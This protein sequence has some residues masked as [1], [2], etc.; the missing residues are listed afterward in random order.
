MRRFDLHTGMAKLQTSLDTLR[1]QWQETADSWRDD[2]R[3][4]FAENYLD[5]IGPTIKIA[6]DAAQRM[7]TVVGEAERDCEEDD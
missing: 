6:L 1:G 7:A 4:K 5:P 2:V 3:H